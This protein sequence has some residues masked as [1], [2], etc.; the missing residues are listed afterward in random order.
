MEFRASVSASVSVASVN[1]AIENACW[2]SS[3]ESVIVTFKNNPEA[4]SPSN[5]S[6]CRKQTLT[7]FHIEVVITGNVKSSLFLSRQNVKIRL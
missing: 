1:Q 6:L 4:M 5:G 3:S 7:I 2:C